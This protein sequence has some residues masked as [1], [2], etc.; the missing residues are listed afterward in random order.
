[1]NEADDGG[2]W[3][4]PTPPFKAAEALVGLRRQL[5]EMKPL[6]ERGERFELKGRPVIE[7]AAGA[8]GIDARLA[9]RP[10]TT[11]DWTPQKLRSGA[12]VRRFVDTVR[13]QLRRWEQED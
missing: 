6:A 7:L 10:A 3:S 8:D 9:R 13:Q 4:I 12:D 2:G 5:R 11:P 1:V